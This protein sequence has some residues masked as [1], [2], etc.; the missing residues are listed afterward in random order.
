MLL[1]SLSVPKEQVVATLRELARPG[2]IGGIYLGDDRTRLF[3]HV[4]EL[5]TSNAEFAFCKS[6]DIPN[7]VWHIGPIAE[8]RRFHKSDW[9]GSR[10]IG[11]TCEFNGGV[12]H[13]HGLDML[14]LPGGTIVRM[15]GAPVVVAADGLSIVEDVSSDYAPLVFFY[16]FDA[17]ARVAQARHV[18]GIAFVLASDI[19]GGNYYHWMID[20]LPR[21]ALLRDRPDV[22]V[23]I[24]DIP[25]PWQ[26]ETLDLL[27]IARSK[28]IALGPDEALTAVT[29]LAPNAIRDM[30]HPG[31]KGAAWVV[32]WLRGR[33]GLSALT[34][35]ALSATAP[36]RLYVGRSDATS[37]R[38]LNEANLLRVL[39][40][41][42]FVSVTL[43]G[44]TI[45]EQAALFA[46][47]EVVIG[48]HGAGLA[49][50]VFCRPGTSVLEVFTPNFGNACFGFLAA[51]NGLRHATYVAEPGRMPADGS[52]DCV[53]DV[54]SFW[55]AVE[56]WLRAA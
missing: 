20:E 54:P 39:E 32:D 36:S 50:I 7:A 24:S 29:L 41:A 27:G 56:P 2:D 4:R 38:L 16:D 52:F 18:D 26:M 48:L 23:V 15:A 1:V 34:R 25:K 46:G 22:T 13:C 17:R 49:N 5:G 14:E 44:R 12:E 30:Q 55:R 6:A 51:S 35:R 45:A 37:R 42:G 11:A 19:S 10:R 31:R 43:F 21:I 33:L 40:P 3:A 8:P 47:A 53:L 28:V 9:L